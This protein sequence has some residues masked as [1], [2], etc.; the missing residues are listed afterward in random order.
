MTID[1][2]EIDPVARVYAREDHSI[3]R[4]DID[5]DALKIMYRLLRA[6]FKAY[7]V[8]G[9]VRDLLLDIKPKD[10]DIGTDASPKQIRSLFRNSRIIG[11]RFRL[12]H[13]YFRGNKIIEVATFRSSSEDDDITD[14]E[15]VKRDNVYGTSATDAFRRD[16]SINALFYDLATFSVIDYVGG[17]E[18]LKQSVIRIIGDPDVRFREDPVRLVRTV[19][20]AARIGFTIEPNTLDSLNRNRELIEQASPVRLYEEMRKDLASGSALP[21][22]RLMSEVGL[23]DYLLPEVSNNGGALLTQGSDFAECVSLCDELVRSGENLST[24][25]IL[26]LMTLY[27][28]EPKIDRIDLP[29]RFSTKTALLDHADS[30]FPKLAVPRKERERIKSILAAWFAL[31][32]SSADRVRSSELA[33]RPFVSDLKSLFRLTAC[34]REDD[35]LIQVLARAE[36]QRKSSE[37]QRKRK[38]RGQRKHPQRKPQRKSTRSNKGSNRRRSRRGPR[39]NSAALPGNNEGNR[40]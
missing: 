15:P 18:D 39:N 36:R 34:S 37:S 21:I 1:G 38:G 8:G 10:F 33:G 29:S 23:L 7:L 35:E 14:G 22:L 30:C 20:H 19:R 28:G 3:S 2:S 4:K 32:H 11:R 40:S 24:T 13:I 17:V 9:G 12:V 16:L 31:A 5:P 26:A 25:A 6:Q 27:I